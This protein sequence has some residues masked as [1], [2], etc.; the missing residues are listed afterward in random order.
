MFERAGALREIPPWAVSEI[1][2]GTGGF[3]RILLPGLVP[4]WIVYLLTVYCYERMY[5]A[6]DPA[7]K[8][9]AE[10]RQTDDSCARTEEP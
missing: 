6:L 9:G 2:A 7:P 8:W 5:T 4:L 10:S 1:R 3:S